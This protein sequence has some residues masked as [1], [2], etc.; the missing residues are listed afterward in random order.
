MGLTSDNSQFFDSGTQAYGN[1]SPYRNANWWVW[2]GLALDTSGTWSLEL[3]ING[4][5]QVLAP[6]L[7][8]EG[9]TVPTNHPPNAVTAVFDP[10]A[11]GT[12]DVVFCRLAVPLLEDPDYDLMRYRYQWSVNGVPIRDVASAAHADAV[13]HGVAQPGD[14]LSCTA[15]P[16]DGALSGPPVTVQ[17][18]IPR[19]GVQLEIQLLPGPQ[20]TL[21]WPAS[22]TNYVLQT[23]STIS[24]NSWQTIT[25]AASLVGGQLK[26]TNRVSDSMFYRLNRQSP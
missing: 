4:Q 9:G 21:S 23:A 17:T 19:P 24:A 12:N 16:F 18:T 10:P 8:V 22:A 2:Y 26:V 3:S 11:P 14:V 7:V 1:T 13:P 20:V 15:T 25:D 6:F 5:V